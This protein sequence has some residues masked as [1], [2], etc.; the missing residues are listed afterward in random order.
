LS[1]PLPNDGRGGCG[2]K[3]QRWPS[4]EAGNR[5]SKG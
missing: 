5:V 2:R 4:T 1:S 3:I